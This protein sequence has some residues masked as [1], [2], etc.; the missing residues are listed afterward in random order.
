LSVTAV[1]VLLV[2][3]GLLCSMHAQ[4]AL[5]STVQYNGCLDQCASSFNLSDETFSSLPISVSGSGGYAS[6]SSSYGTLKATVETAFEGD[7]TGFTLD[8]TGAANA[9]FTDFVTV[10][11]S[12][13]VGEGRLIVH[14]SGSFG[15]QGD[16]DLYAQSSAGVT[17]S[18]S[19]IGAQGAYIGSVPD[20]ETVIIFFPY[21]YGDPLSLSMQLS[22]GAAFGGIA[23]FGH[24]AT[25]EFDLPEGAYL[26][27]DSGTAYRQVAFAV[28]EPASLGMVLTGMLGIFA[29]RRRW[30]TSG[31]EA[32][33]LSG[34]QSKPKG[35]LSARFDESSTQSRII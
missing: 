31:D 16:F 13:G 33:T 9:S 1:K 18:V 11:G 3:V 17:V 19:G 34:R 23:N 26:Q 28:P 8:T 32:E 10:L 7:A 30:R 22:V 6:A 4:A 12:T 2:A 14:I 25:L 21:Y 35:R 15:T 20:H 29:T 5:Y 27:A 24:T